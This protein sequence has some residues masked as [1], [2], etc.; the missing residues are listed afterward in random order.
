[1][2]NRRDKS[3][4]MRILTSIA[5]FLLIGAFVYVFIAGINFYTGVVF[6]AALIGL[7]IPAVS[8]AE[9]IWE[10][11]AGFFKAFVDGVAE[12]IGGITEAI[13]SIFD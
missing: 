8:E 7:G 13:S 11:I 6:G 9:S 1:M 12:V 2:G 10:I 4:G 3:V 5:A